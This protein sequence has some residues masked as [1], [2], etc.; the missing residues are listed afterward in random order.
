MDVSE[1]V[2]TRRSI[3]AYLDTP[4]SDDS[5]RELLEKASRAPSGGNVQPWRIFVINGAT[6]GRFLEFLATRT[7]PEQTEYDIY[8]R[9]PQGALP[10]VA[11]QA[12]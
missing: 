10:L 11:I 1:A 6:M 9:G 2:A 8:P 3:R 12:G 4:V 5:I 7:D